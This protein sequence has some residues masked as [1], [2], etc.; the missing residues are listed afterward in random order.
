MAKIAGQNFA[1]YADGTKIGDA[2]DCTL[3][4]SQTLIDATSKDDANWLA[5]LTSQREWSIDVTVVFDEAN[6]F[7]VV[8]LNDLILNATQVVVEFSQGTDG[9]TY[10]YGNAYLA[11]CN[12]SAPM[13]DVTTA[14]AT[15][16]GDGALTKASITGS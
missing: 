12:I 8:D 9:T 16:T 3:N 13:A 2:R 1:V 4:V 10:W 5:R 11:S 6:A 7:D 15:F 14:S